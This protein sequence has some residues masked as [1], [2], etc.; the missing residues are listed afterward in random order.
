MTLL[1]RFLI[2]RWDS[3]PRVGLMGLD[4]RRIGQ[5]VL[6]HGHV[7][8]VGP[9]HGHVGL[10]LCPEVVISL[11]CYQESANRSELFRFRNGVGTLALLDNLDSALVMIGTRFRWSES[12]RSRQLRIPV[13]SL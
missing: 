9:G 10:D 1:H 13:S 6:I 7:G 2:N 12:L 4:L 8:L 5:L 3:F 11:R